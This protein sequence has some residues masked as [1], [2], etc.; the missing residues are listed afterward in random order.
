MKT[1]DAL[2]ISYDDPEG[3]KH[4]IGLLIKSLVQKII[5][6]YGSTDISSY[7]F[8]EEMRDERIVL[9]RENERMGKVNSL[10]RALEYSGSDILVMMSSDISFNPGFISALERYFRDEQTCAVVPCVIPKKESG[11][12]HAAGT[13]LWLLRNDM[14]EFL[15]RKNGFVH[16]GELLALRRK[17][18]NRLPAVTNDEE[19]LCMNLS[20]SGLRVRYAG[21]IIVQNR[22]PGSVSDYFIQRKRVIFGHWQMKSFGFHPPV[23]DFMIPAHPVLFTRTLIS[24][25]V[26][27][28]ASMAALPVLAFMESC[29]LVMSRSYE[30]YSDTVKWEFAA[31]TKLSK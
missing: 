2:V 22:T 12:I 13:L 1:I 17:A 21:D 6:A 30:K 23:L 16:G 19:Y 11:L 15:D 5:V 10:N 4:V 24:T 20:E 18:I 26:K 29:A 31:S 27:H 14:L 9:L 25:L 28:P 7:E 3:I 8:L